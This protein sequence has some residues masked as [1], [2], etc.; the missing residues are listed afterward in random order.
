MAMGQ[1]AVPTGAM[2]AE[3]QLQRHGPRHDVLDLVS[4]HWNWGNTV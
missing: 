3:L 2:V 1:T 4:E